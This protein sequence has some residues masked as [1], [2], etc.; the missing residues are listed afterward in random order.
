M[1]NDTP[2]SFVTTAIAYVNGPPHLG[3]AQEYVLA[4]AI[5]RQRRRQGWDVRFQSGTDDNSL[6]TVRAAASAGTTPALLVA[7]NSASFTRLAGTLDVDFDDFVK[8]SS[9]RR[10]A[11]AVAEL[12]RACARAGDIYPRAYRGL[13]CGGCEQ[14]FAEG[15]LESNFC[16]EHAT[17]LEAI[18]ENNYFFR[19]SRYGEHVRRLV[20]ADV[21]HVRPAARKHEILGFLE[22]GLADFSVSRPRARAR[23][24][25]IPVPGD[26]EQVVY[27]WFDAL[28]NYI[29]ALGYAGD[30]S[31]LERYWT[32]ST[33]RTHVIGKGILRFHAAYWPAILLSAGLELPSELLVHGYVTVEGRKIGKSLGNAVD[34]FELIRKQGRDAFRYYVLRQLHTTADSDFSEARLTA[35]RASELADQLGNLLRRTLVLVQQ[36]CPGRAPSPGELTSHD[37]ELRALGERA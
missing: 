1:S 30:P 17:A 20:E 21:L 25:G 7:E 10:H 32:P 4:D 18:E 8:T 2:R 35:L 14:F 36:R 3:H 37:A 33:R 15:E 9:D 16:P 11:P 12:W 19:A 13:Y 22:R 28:A 24:W 23:G 26:P 27:V 5:V 6:K 31:L 29:S 34:P